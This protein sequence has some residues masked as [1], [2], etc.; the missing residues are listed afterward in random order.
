MGSIIGSKVRDDGKIVF[1]VCV[2]KKEAMQLK[3]QVD[4]IYLMAFDAH[5]E[6]TSVVQRGKNEATMYF[7]VPKQV[8]DK[9]KKTDTASFQKLELPRKKFFIYVTKNG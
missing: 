7:L 3:G 1:E 6:E 2:D 8:R 9:L 5:A 4:E